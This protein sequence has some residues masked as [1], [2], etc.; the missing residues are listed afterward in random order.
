MKFVKEFLVPT[1]VLTVICVVVSAAL[2]FTYDTTKPVIEAARQREADA[3]RIEVLPDADKFSLLTVSGIDGLVDAYEAA[4]GA[5]YVITTYSGGYGGPVNVMTGIKADGT[6][7]A[8]KLMTNSESA[9]IGTRVGE[10]AYTD[11]YK[12]KDYGLDGVSAV[13][14]ATVSS[15]AFKRAVEAAFQVYA[16]VAG[17]EI[18]EP[19]PPEEQIFPNATDF[20]EFELEGAK[21]AYMAAGE[22]IVVVMEAKGYSG[23]PTPMEVYVGFGTDFKIAGVALGEN[24]ETSG[25]GTQTGESAYTD[26]YKGRENT[27]G[28]TAVSGATESSKGFKGAVDAALELLP[29]I[30]AKMPEVAVAKYAAVLPGVTQVTPLENE[31]AVEAVAAPG[32]GIVA[33]TQYRGYNE[34]SPVQV[35][36][37]ISE[38]GAITGVKIVSCQETEG[39][40]SQIQGD[41]YLGAWTGKKAG[42]NAAAISGATVSSTA[43]QR[44]V[45]KAFLVFEASKGA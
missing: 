15:G 30:Q 27:E 5:G 9:G 11:Q 25:L 45:E 40:G 41:A 10:P 28:I 14:G 1:L 29:A 4:N 43:F 17:V 7:A 37:G 26:Q 18:A 34:N 24:S 32:L 6:I 12:G 16:Q 19:T 42:E 23:A 8:V 20:V 3:A 13:S 35:M 2:V 44:C 38:D 21:R 33:V 36:V 39:I 22:G 31:N